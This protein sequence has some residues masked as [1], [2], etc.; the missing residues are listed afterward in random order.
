MGEVILIASIS[1]LAQTSPLALKV[2]STTTFLP[3]KLISFP[4]ITSSTPIGVIFL[5]STFKDAVT[6]R[7]GKGDFRGMFSARQINAAADP[8]P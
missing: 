4:F 6:Q 7:T 3:D 2:M 1:D 5:K 8:V